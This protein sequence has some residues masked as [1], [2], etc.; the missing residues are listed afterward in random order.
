MSRNLFDPNVIRSIQASLSKNC[1]SYW[2][3][4]LEKTGVRV[5]KTVIIKT[6]VELGRLFDEETPE[7]FDGFI[8]ELSRAAFSVAGEYYQGSPEGTGPFF[9]RTGMLSG[10]HSWLDTCYVP[11]IDDLPDHVFNL[12]EESAMCDML[13]RPFNVWAVREF[14]PM[15]SAFTAF[16]GL[17]INKERRYFIKD[18]EVLCYHSYW[19]E[20]AVAEGE[21]KDSDGFPWQERLAYINV[22]PL[23]SEVAFLSEQARKVSR[24]FEGAWSLDFSQ[25]KTGEWI[26]IDMAVAEESWHWPDCPNNV[27]VTNES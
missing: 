1:L 12:C 24:A 4:I 11:S 10:K 3:P 23:D 18:V 21:P 17:P 13:G 16:N 14:I 5:P 25:A 27:N 8:E 19:P 15:V 22:Q 20:D 2:F 9:L 6:E 7:G 26:A